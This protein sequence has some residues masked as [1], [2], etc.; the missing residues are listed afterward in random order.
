VLRLAVKNEAPP[1]KKILVLAVRSEILKNFVLTHPGKFGRMKRLEHV[2]VLFAIVDQVGD[3][4]CAA[5]PVANNPDYFFW[6]VTVKE[7]V[8]V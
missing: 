6:L 2:L 5:S 4:G 1:I 3:P 8:P 7:Y